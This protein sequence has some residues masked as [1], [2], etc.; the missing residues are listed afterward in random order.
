MK[1][2]I[3]YFDDNQIKEYNLKAGENTILFKPRRPLPL[4]GGSGPSNKIKN[5]EN[6]YYI[7]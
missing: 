2:Y 1:T 7:F 5:N 6:I 3:T 4:G